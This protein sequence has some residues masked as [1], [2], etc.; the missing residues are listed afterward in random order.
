MA[1]IQHAQHVQA[2]DRL[3]HGAARD[4]QAQRQIALGVQPIA[5]AELARGDHGH[6][7]GGGLLGGGCGSDA[8]HTGAYCGR[9]LDS[10]LAVPVVPRSRGST[11]HAAQ[12]AGQVGDVGAGGRSSGFGVSGGHRIVY[13][14]VR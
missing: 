11:Q 13:L 10:D 9:D 3:A 8:L 14:P 7:R 1:D 4:T 2:A 5:R 6:D 12:P